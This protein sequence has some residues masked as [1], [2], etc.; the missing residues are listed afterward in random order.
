M[1]IPAYLSK[2]DTIGLVSPAKATESA[3]I[4]FAI[5]FWES[6][7]FKVKV[8]DYCGGQYHYFAGQDKERLFDFQMMLDDP[9][10]KA[11]ICT[12][13]GYGCVRIVDRINWS[14][15][16]DA[17]KW[18]VGFSDVT[19][20][21]QHLTKLGVASLHA[22]MPLNYPTNTDDALESMLTFLMGQ[23]L[24]YDWKTH[25][26]K[27]GKASGQ[28]VGGNLAVLTALIGTDSMP[29]YSGALLFL[30]DVGEYLYSIDRMFFSLSKAG[31]LDKIAGLIIGDFSNVKDTEHPFGQQL[32]E[33]ILQHV[34]YRNIPV[35]FG[36]PMGHCE[37]NR[38]IPSGI[39]GEL[40]VGKNAA[41]LE[42]RS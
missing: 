20:F 33:I 16:L 34:A 4:E 21:H 10:V 11:I 23:S 32:H 1:L 9:E 2:G 30:E 15:C 8:G 37:D 42:I 38:A 6:N 13:G 27:Q 36:F 26:G 39:K 7:G 25:D 19:V 17:P 29:N 41:R 18:I 40:I 5:K 14:G 31:I 12:R 28:L 35:A 3:Y 24:A 22:T